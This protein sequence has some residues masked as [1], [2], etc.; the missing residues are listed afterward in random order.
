[1][2]PPEKLGG[3]RNAASRALHPL[4]QNRS[5]TFTRDGVAGTLK[6][7][8]PRHDPVVHVDIVVLGLPALEADHGPMVAAAEG[9]DPALLGKCT[10]CRQSVQVGLGPRVGEAHLLYAEALTYLAGKDLLLGRVGA[11]VEARLVQ[12][13]PDGREDD[14]VGVPV[15]SRRKLTR[16]VCV[17]MSL[18]A[19]Q[20]LA[21]HLFETC[22]CPSSEVTWYPLPDLITTGNGLA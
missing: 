4:H 18:L 10:G 21:Q 16:Q 17:S 13:V 22:V 20:H 6:I 9:D 8:I 7:V 1:M 11:H 15:E 12:D 3:P 5:D 14:G 2:N 19:M